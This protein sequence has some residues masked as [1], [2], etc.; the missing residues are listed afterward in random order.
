MKKYLFFIILFFTLSFNSAFATTTI[1][2]TTIT[3]LATSTLAYIGS[4]NF[5]LGIIITLLFIVI[6][7]FMFNNMHIR[8]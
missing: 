8:K 1:A 7:G 6:L 5:G 2:T 4:I 3:T